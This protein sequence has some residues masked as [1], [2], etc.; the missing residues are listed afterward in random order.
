MAQHHERW[1]GSGYLDGL[2][3]TEIALSA[4]ILAIADTYYD[5]VSTGPHRKAL[6]PHEA[7]EYIMAYSGDLFD[8]EL[9]Q[10]FARNVPLYPTGV[11]VR[12]NTGASGIISDANLGHIGRP[13]VRICHD[14]E[15][16]PVKRPYDVNLSQARHQNLLVEHV[17][18][19]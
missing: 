5:L 2:S 11:V 12:L 13:T 3:G 17:L 10:L 15:G 18:E 14:Q 6:M 7:V 4:R 16:T 1:D 9:V 8:P 19:Y